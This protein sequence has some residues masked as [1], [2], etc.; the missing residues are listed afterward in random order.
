MFEGIRPKR[1]LDLEGSYNIRDLGGYS[2]VDGRSTCWKTFLRADSLHQ[3]ASKS[4]TTLINYGIRAVIDLRDSVEVHDRPNVFSRSSEVAYYHQ[5]LRGDTS[6]NEEK[7]MR[8]SGTW[9]WVTDPSEIGDVS[10][11]SA[12]NYIRWLELRKPRVHGV[13]A[14]LADPTLRPA[15]FHCAAGKDRT[16]VVAALLLAIAGVPAEIIAEDYS[17]TAPFFVA[18]YLAEE[19][20][21]EVSAECYDWRDY[22]RDF[23]PPGAILKVL[24]H[25]DDTYGGVEAYL[26]GTGL[27]EDQVSSIR[28]AFVE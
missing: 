10:E 1:H 5:S 14:L 3:L 8:A 2:T 11:R 18:K 21:P 15:I 25:L 4:Q 24:D 6:Y 27:S 12:R 26:C 22:Q 28:T 13:L 20:P 23:C 7:A 17:L 19:A 16:G 9:P